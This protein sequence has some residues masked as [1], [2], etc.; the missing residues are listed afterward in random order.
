RRRQPLLTRTFLEAIDRQVLQVARQATPPRAAAQ[1]ATASPL[2]LVE[3]GEREETLALSR[4][5]AAA[6]SAL[7]GEIAALR[8][9]TAVLRGGVDPESVEPPA[10]PQAVAH[11]FRD[12]L[13][14]L[15]EL[16][17]PER[18]IAY[19]HFERQAIGAL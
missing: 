9:R 10:T 1:P 12:A 3:E 16:P 13:A 4:M 2:A 14:V 19:K 11:A 5:V 6:E 18:L 8:E 7:A 17:L 15:P